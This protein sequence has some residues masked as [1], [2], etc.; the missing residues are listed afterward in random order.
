[1]RR[2]RNST[3]MRWRSA[4]SSRKLSRRSSAS[5]TIRR[6]PVL[7]LLAREVGREQEHLQ[8]AVLV[9]RVGEL[10]PARR[11]RGRGR[12]PPWPPRTARARRPRR[13]PPW[14][15]SGS[16]CRQRREVDLA[17]RLLDQAAVVVRGQRLARDLLGGDHGEV[18]DLL[19]DLLER[20]AR[21]G[22]DVAPRGRHQLLALL[23][24]LRLRLVG[25]RLGRLARARRRCPPP[26]RGPRA[27][28]RGTPRAARRPRAWP[29]RRARSS[30]RSPCGA[31]RAPRRCAGRRAC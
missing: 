23:G 8:V 3:G 28:A 19:A 26:A 16:P 27:A 12:R 2:I 5:L 25:Q 20:A 30:P 9:E 7:L 17:E 22:L 15:S 6:T 24:G 14:P 10:R 13:S 18:G 11:A 29:A 4:S 1:M 31:C 21:L